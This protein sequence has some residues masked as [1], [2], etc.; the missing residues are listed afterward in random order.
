MYASVNWFNIG[1]VN[2]L[3][4]DQHQAI[5]WTTADLSSN[6]PSETNLNDT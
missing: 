6:G 3:S 4:P 1:S 5:T 2:G